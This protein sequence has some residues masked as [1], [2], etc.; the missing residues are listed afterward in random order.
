MQ[1]TDLNNLRDHDLVRGTLKL[2]SLA[3]HGDFLTIHDIALTEAVALINGQVGR[4]GVERKYKIYDDTQTP[5]HGYIFFDAINRDIA[6]E[7]IDA[8]FDALTVC[9]VPQWRGLR[10]VFISEAYSVVVVGR[11]VIYN[12]NWA[13]TNVLDGSIYDVIQEISQQYL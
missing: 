7:G 13:S 3:V 10:P 5:S 2:P 12:K 11:T 4:I 1:S 9:K 8:I 6:A